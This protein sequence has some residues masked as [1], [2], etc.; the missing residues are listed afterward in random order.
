MKKKIAIFANFWSADIIDMFF[1]GLY[2]SVPEETMDFYIFFAANSYGRDAVLNKSEM[3][4]CKLPILKDYDVAIVFSQSLNSDEYREEI[5]KLCDEAGIPTIV[6]GDKQDRYHSITTNNYPGMRTLVEHLYDVH[7]ARKFVFV[8]GTKSHPDSAFRLKVLKDFAKE[9]NLDFSE[10]DVFYS[11]WEIIPTVEYIRDKYGNGEMLPDAIVCANDFLAMGACTALDTINRECPREVIITG[12]DN[13]RSNQIYYP[14]ITTVN[15]NY[16]KAGQKVA[17]IILNIFNGNKEITSA[18]IDT[19]CVIAESCSCK[20]PVHERNRNYF[21]HTKIGKEYDSNHRKGRLFVLAHELYESERCNQVAPRLQKVFYR[22]DGA[23]G[24]CFHIMIDKDFAKLAYKDVSELP[25]YTYTDEF[26][27]IVSKIDGSIAMRD[28]APRRELIPQYRGYGPNRIFIFMPIYYKTFACGYVCMEGPYHYGEEWKYNE[29]SE[30][31]NESL[32]NFINNIKLT[33]LNDQ[34]SAIMHT[35]ALTHVKNRNAFE[36]FKEQLH[37]EF[38][39]DPGIKFA[40][41]MF[42]INNLKQI[43]DVLG[44]DA[45]DQYIKNCCGLICK[46]FNHSAVFRLGGDEFLAILRE[47]KDFDDLDEHMTRL[48]EVLKKS[49]NEPEAVDRIS[50]ATGIGFSEEISVDEYDK[51]FKLADERMYEN[52]KIMKSQK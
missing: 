48:N 37:L 1:D 25:Q 45:G 14:A 26:T 41:A 24:G 40:I 44:H 8:A 38:V 29:Y 36:E 28:T 46:T 47:G 4:I 42:D 12:Y 2:K 39:K 33:S 22:E 43:N 50:F 16:D 35:D 17:E 34:L 5:Y 52:K 13:V 18:E 31:I 19:E 30:C 6:I 49:K 32:K 20:S 11:N 7:K 21:C 3:T 23:E 9:K 51:V 10:E 27:V 15:Q